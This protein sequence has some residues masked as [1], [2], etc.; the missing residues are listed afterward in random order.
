[1][2]DLA[3]LP[4]YRARLEASRLPAPWRLDDLE[5]YAAAHDDPFAGR[6]AP[7][8]RVQVALQVEATA[9]PPIWTALGDG[10]L[11]PWAAGLARIWL[12]LG[13]RAGDTI[14]FFD[15]GSNPAV[16]L[17]TKI[18]VAHLKKGA[19][20]RIG[21]TAICNDGVASMTARMLGI[22]ESVKPAVL[23]VRRDLVA[24]LVD[25]LGTRGMPAESR[26]RRA[27]IGETEGAPE[28]AEAERLERALAVPVS[29]WLRADAAFFLAADCTTCRR[30]HVDPRLYDAEPADDGDA[31]VTAR[32]AA[33][34]PAVRYRIGGRWEPPGCT[35]ETRARRIAWP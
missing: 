31:L 4:F 7:G 9:D 12:R 19:T 13:L 21:A 28:V 5:D 25:A 22:L 8:E 14:A 23:F 16:L 30:F 24:P 3:S 2:S 33:R 34:C 20:D 1:L 6:V 32:F 11:D 17:S 35:A 29:R 15:Y 10:E 26:L 18:F 27:V